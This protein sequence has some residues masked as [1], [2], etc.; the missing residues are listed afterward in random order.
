MTFE[1]VLRNLRLER[2]LTQAE[3]SRK[4][5]LSGSSVSMYERG[6]R[7]P[8]YEVQEAIADFFNVDMDFLMGRT[9]VRRR[10]TFTPAGPALS[11]DE[12]ALLDGYRALSLQ[13][14]QYLL[15]TLDLATRVYTEK[16]GD[17]SDVDDVG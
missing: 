17:S 15:Q 5:G 3:L 10:Y 16:S 2:K 11:P 9:D 1:Q 6:E 8:S 13:G 7:K 12:Q 14:K 4:L